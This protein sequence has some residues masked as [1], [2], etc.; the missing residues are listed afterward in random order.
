[1]ALRS[2]GVDCAAVATQ[3]YIEDRV[4]WIL[5]RLQED[6]PDVFVPNAMLPSYYAGRWAR[7]AGI[8]TVGILHSDDS[9]HRGLLNEFVFGDTDYRLSALVC[10]SRFL[11]Q[12]VLRRRPHGVL[13]RRIPCGV[14]IP[15]DMAQLPTGRMRLVYTGR[16]VEEQKRISEL[17]RALC[18]VV[19][20][21]ESTEAFIYGEG[22]AATQV[23]QI[24]S[25]DGNGLPIHFAGRVDSDRIQEH[26]Q[27][28]HVLVLLS[29]YEGLP[30]SMMEAMASGVVPICL[31][32]RSGAVELIEHDKTGLLVS[33]R[34]DDFVNAAR[35]LRC[36][37]DTW[38]RLSL[39]ARAKMQAEYSSEASAASWET[40][41]RALSD[42]SQTKRV[43]KAPRQ[44]V[45]PPIPAA[46][47]HGHMRKPPFLML[48]L[49]GGWRF[50]RRVFHR[51]LRRNSHPSST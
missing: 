32:T 26:L 28:G 7:E 1:M 6:P 46:L 35:R 18:R 36:E 22:P 30:I 44:V 51:V 41:L 27:K 48:V 42:N 45:L 33:N 4:R 10:V 13:I 11:E 24:V 8:P 25:S 34:G 17:T 43:V 14:P 39:A 21:V 5:K 29:D 38:E 40:L 31:R 15:E 16:L 20:E 12:E 19:R 3:T 37:P 2:Q 49:R 23:D 50:A 9:Y 47:A